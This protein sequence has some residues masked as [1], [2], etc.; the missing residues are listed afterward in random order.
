MT[1]PDAGRERLIPL[2][3]YKEPAMPTEEAFRRLLGRARA[4]IARN[5][6][7]PFIADDRLQKVTR[8]T[9]DEIVAP[10]ACGPLLA[11]LERTVAAWLANE[12]KLPHLKVVVLPPCEQNGLIETWARQSGHQIVPPPA[13]V[14]LIAAEAP[15][16]PDLGGEGVLVVP[17]LE[18]WLLRHRSGLRT[19]RALL[20]A[21]DALDRRVVIGCNSWAWAFL[22]KAAGADLLLPDP[23]SFRAFDA[24]RLHRWFL[25]LSTAEATASVKFRLPKTGE[26]VM[27]EDDEG[28]L[29]S[30]FLATLAGRSL[31]IPW[32]AWHM[33]RRS[34]R[35]DQEQA[36]AED[37]EAMASSDESTEAGEQT[38]W[39]AALDDYVLPGKTEQ[40]GLL[41]LHALLIHGPLS[42][43]HLRL[44]LP[45]V[46][47]SNIVPVL[48]KAGF[49]QRTGDTLACA[50]AAYPAIRSGLA[51]AGMPIGRF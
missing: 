13:R 37:M 30:D 40:T 4:L 47:E 2:D 48:V 42:A 12:P 22:G 31:G 24:A 33:W 23:V 3:D 10:P 50:P 8:D 35:S 34:M 19:V 27:E 25:E 6:P 43:E 51:A 49:L 28:K 32:V 46:G 18:A 45:I 29:K 41:V 15:H 26:N 21:L 9:L 36:V 5:D 17:Q 38:L 39:I 16:L 20:A 1:D 44:V 14:S 7:K 11:E